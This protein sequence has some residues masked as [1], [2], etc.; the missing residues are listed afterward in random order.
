[1]EKERILSDYFYDQ[2]VYVHHDKVILSV[3]ISDEH[4]FP[5]ELVD[6]VIPIPLPGEAAIQIL[7]SITDYGDRLRTDLTVDPCLIGNLRSDV[8][9][10]GVTNDALRVFSVLESQS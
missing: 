5:G 9:E 1:M 6:V 2:F 3:R 4:G 8:R 10:A 7:S